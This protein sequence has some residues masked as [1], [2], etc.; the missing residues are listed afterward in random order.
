MD[1][2]LN[3]ARWNSLRKPN[4][5][6]PC[7]AEVDRRQHLYS[8]GQTGTGK[9][10]LFFQ[11]ILD[12]VQSG[13]GVGIIDPHGDL[14]EAVLS[15][16]PESRVKDVILFEPADIGAPNGLN[17]LQ[18]DRTNPA[19]RSFI[20]DEMLRIFHAL[21]DLKQTGGPMFEAYVRAVVMLV[22]SDTTYDATLV[23]CERVFTDRSFRDQLLENCPDETVVR[24]WKELAV[25]AGGDIFTIKHGPLHYQQV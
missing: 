11:M 2:S 12:D 9:S 10:S 25:R 20:V 5:A 16:M 22:L 14:V 23:D 1:D 4:L 24:F 21:Y 17:M 15:A 18:W 8:I 19:E 13:H 7:F 3:S 6:V